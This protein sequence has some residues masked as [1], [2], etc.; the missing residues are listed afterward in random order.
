MADT[1]RAA[2]V[3]MTAG[4]DVERSAAIL[5]SSILDAA[6]NGAAFVSTPEMSNFL[7]ARKAQALERAV[8]EDK[9]QTLQAA[10]SA[11]FEAGCWVHIGSL[12]LKGAGDKLVN[13]GFLINPNGDIIARY[14]KIHMFDVDLGAGESYRESALYQR[15]N[16][17]V[18]VETPLAT[19]GLTICY[20]VRFPGLYASL[21][22]AG[23]CVML[24]PAA[25]TQPTGEA[26]WDTLLR[27]RAVENT[28]FVL[29][30]G[31]T[32]QHESGRKTHGHSIAIDPWGSTIGALERAP[33][34]LYADINMDAVAQTRAKIPSLG[35]AKTFELERIKA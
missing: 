16:H 27:A 18:V 31:Q 12:C 7:P 22:Q 28:C 8:E 1:W 35:H 5:S 14:D 19:F 9:D 32:G 34:I 29:A 6:K 13:R 15:G 33:G 21:A 25:F 23:A 4:L 3:Q 26:H 20:D 11:A 17:C 2:L 30:A 10:R 24:V